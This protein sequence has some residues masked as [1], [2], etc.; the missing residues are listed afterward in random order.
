MILKTYNRLIIAN[1]C[2]INKNNYFCETW[3]EKLT[4]YIIN[5]LDIQNNKI[6]MYHEIYDMQVTMKIRNVNIVIIAGKNNEIIKLTC[7]KYD[8]VKTIYVYINLKLTKIVR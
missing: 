7:N 3:Y 4:E 2:T 6:C 1:K 5:V 8:L